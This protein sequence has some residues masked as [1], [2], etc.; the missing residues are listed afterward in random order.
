MKAADREYPITSYQP[1]Y[2]VARTLD[3]AKAR[4]V[5]FC[6]HLPRPFYARY[7]AATQRIWVDRAVSR[8]SSAA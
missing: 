6:R 8:Q 2:F 4:M 7:N 1:V 3:Q 5:E